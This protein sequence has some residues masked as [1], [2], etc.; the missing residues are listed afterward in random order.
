MQELIDVETVGKISR[1]VLYKN[2][3]VEILQI[4]VLLACNEMLRSVGV[5]MDGE[6]HVILETLTGLKGSRS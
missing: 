5:K 2:Y 3:I 1:L 4:H 6:R